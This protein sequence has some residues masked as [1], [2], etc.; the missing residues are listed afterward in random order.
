MDFLKERTSM[1]VNPEGCYLGEI[2]NKKV[3]FDVTAK[4]DEAKNLLVL[5]KIGEGMNYRQ[6]T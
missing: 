5:G 4:T 1:N 3:Y 2:K 6:I